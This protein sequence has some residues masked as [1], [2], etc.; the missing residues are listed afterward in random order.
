MKDFNKIIIAITVFITTS[1]PITAQEMIFKSNFTENLSSWNKYK[2]VE[3]LSL[4]ENGSLKIVATGH[5]GGIHRP[6]IVKPGRMYNVFTE[7]K[8]KGK[9]Q[10]AVN[11][12]SGFAYSGKIELANDKWTKIQVSYFETGNRFSVYIFSCLETPE[13][14]FV[15]DIHITELPGKKLPDT[16]VKEVIL[17]AKDYP[18]THAKEKDHPSVKGKKVLWGSKWYRIVSFPVPQTSKP[19]FIYA[20]AYSTDSN[21]CFLRLYRDQQVLTQAPVTETEKWSWIKLGPVSVSAAGN[22]LDISAQCIKG[23]DVYIDILALST[24]PNLSVQ[25]E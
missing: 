8:G 25:G 22:R 2:N 14:Y 21:N 12:S 10:L 19:I 24:N 17:K 13:T 7:V 5:L 6:I 15:K 16:A 18:G 3:S 11:G 9:V 4:E 23:T 20:K 1:F